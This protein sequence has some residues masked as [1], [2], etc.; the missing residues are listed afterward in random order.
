MSTNVITPALDPIVELICITILVTAVLVFA[1]GEFMI[2]SFLDNFTVTGTVTIAVATKQKR[3]EKVKIIFKEE[4]KF[5]DLTGVPLHLKIPAGLESFLYIRDCYEVFIDDIVASLP[6]KPCKTIAILGTAGIGKSSLFLVVLKLL[7]ED[8]SVF[9]LATRSFYFQTLP[10]EIWLYHHVHANDFIVHCLER[11]ERLDAAIPLFA[12]METM[13][14]SPKKHAGISIIFTLFGPSCY[15]E[16]TKQGWHKVLPTWSAE[17]QAELFNSIQFRTKYS[18][19]LA[20]HAY[21]N[22][23]YFG[24]SV[25][26]NIQATRR[27][28]RPLDLIESAILENGEYIC[29]RF[30]QDGFSGIEGVMSDILLHRNPEILEGGVYD[31]DAKPYAFS[32]ASSYVLRRLLAYKNNMMVADAKNKYN[33]GTYRVGENGIEFELLCLHGFKISDVEFVAQP[34]TFGTKAMKVT[35]PPKQLLAMNWREQEDYLQAN[36]LYISPYGNLESGNAFCLMK[37]KRK[38]TLVILQCTIAENHPVKQNG[39]KIIHDCYKKNRNLPLDDTVI[40]FIIP[41]N[42]KLK[43]KQPLIV[44]QKGEEAHEVQRVTIAVTAQYRIENKLVTLDQ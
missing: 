22:I 44:Q 11:G 16:L 39:V 37:I 41:F 32:F 34:L 25:R 5:L 4:G 29:E 36:V 9:G 28:T 7:L 14:G 33:T 23:Q 8:P 12:D 1:H 31:F 38:W 17:E 35:F 6:Q 43:T 2:F 19:Q 42:G 26:N 20:L 40:M 27:G 13:E 30:F 18:E 10:G 15:K 21:N 24:G 3:V